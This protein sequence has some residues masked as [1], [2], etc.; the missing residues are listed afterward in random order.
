M[1]LRKAVSVASVLVFA[2]LA[3]VYYR[4]WSDDAGLDYTEG[5]DHWRGT[6]YPFD[7]AYVFVALSDPYVRLALGLQAAL[8][9]VGSTRPVV[10][11][12]GTGVGAAAEGAMALSGLV[13]K[14][15]PPS[16]R[17]ANY[18]PAFRRWADL[19]SKLE[20]FRVPVQRVVFL[21]LDMVL[22]GNPDILFNRTEPFV[23]SQDNWGCR[24]LKPGTVN[25]GVM[26]VRHNSRTYAGLMRTLSRGVVTNGDQEIIEKYWKQQ[27]GR[28]T[29]LAES[30]STFHTRFSDD[31]ACRW[32]Y[33]SFRRA[34]IVHLAGS[35]AKW[36]QVVRLGEDTP[37]MSEWARPFMGLFKRQN[38]L[39]GV[40][41]LQLAR[42]EGVDPAV[43][44]F[45][46]GLYGNLE[47]DTQ[48]EEA[49]VSSDASTGAANETGGQSGAY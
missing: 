33:Q 10:V 8:R 34:R 27:L 14:R 28:V 32:L 15:I 25:S 11:L 26:F 30:I 38:D 36:E 6:T 19:L 49:A 22:R 29:T 5:S 44:Q 46:R 42:R 16:P 1:A 20:V 39:A 43:A 3:L 18:R 45:V 48:P 41:M 4:Y 17:H 40:R 21:D 9:D 37:R 2:T 12:A 31:K 35:K 23:A 13:V 47:G 7:E 24:T